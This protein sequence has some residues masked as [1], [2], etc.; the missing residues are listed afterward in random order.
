MLRSSLVNN[1]TQAQIFKDLGIAH[2]VFK[3]GKDKDTIQTKEKAD[4][5]EGIQAG[6]ISDV[7]VI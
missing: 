4:Y 6:L 2:Y 7:F 1:L 3:K 5:V